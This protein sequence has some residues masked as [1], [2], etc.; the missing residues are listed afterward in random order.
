MRQ[1]FAHIVFDIDGTL[2]DTERAVL[3]SLHD[4]LLIAAGRDVPEEEL[5]FAL[6]IPGATALTRLGIAHP[7]P[8]VGLW[9]RFMA[10]HADAVRL[11]DGVEALLAVLQARGCRTGVVTSKTRDEYETEFERPYGMAGRFDAV[12]CAGETARPKPAPDPLLAYMARTGARPADVLYVGDTLYDARCA[13]AAGAS[14]GLARWGGGTPEAAAVADSVFDHPSEVA[15]LA[16]CPGPA[17]P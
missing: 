6:G 1:L 13:R 3:Q 5:R 2:L 8:V 4:T 15:A 17:A 7:E 12:V 14:F 9:N 16:A 10:R 11:F